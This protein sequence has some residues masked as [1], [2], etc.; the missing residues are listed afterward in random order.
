MPA[1]D[2]GES[3]TLIAELPTRS[4]AMRV[5]SDRT[6]VAERDV[7]ARE[8]VGSRTE[9]RTFLVAVGQD[10]LHSQVVRGRDTSGRC[11]WGLPPSPEP[12]RAD[13]QADARRGCPG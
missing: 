9:L 4:A 1:W 8:S 5:K 2:A 11:G 12:S 3:V 6:F 10:V 13:R 7:A